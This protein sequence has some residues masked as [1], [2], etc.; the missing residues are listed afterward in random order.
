MK[1]PSLSHQTIVVV[2]TMLLLSTGA[3]SQQPIAVP[4]DS[5]I[6]VVG[7][8]KVSIDYGRPSIHGRKIMGDYVQYNRVWRTGSGK[9][10]TLITEA[11][12]ELGGVEIPM[13]SYSLWT[14][15]S[16]NQWKL[17]IN[18]EVGQWGT[19]YNSEQDLARISLHMK[20]LSKSVDK[21]TFYLDRGSNSSGALRIEWEYTSLSVPF[22]VSSVPIIATRAP[23]E[24]GGAAPGDKNI[25]GNYI[26]VSPRDSTEI[27]LGGKKIAVSYSRPS[28]R[29][30]KIVGSLVPYDKVWRTGANEAT[31]L[32]TQTDLEV[33][34]MVVPKGTYTLYTLPSRAQWKLIINKQTGQWGTEYNASRDLARIKLEKKRLAQLVEKFTIALEHGPG[35]TGILK[36]E[37]EKTSLSIPLALKS[38]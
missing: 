36:I 31:K 6:V 22:K 23:F 27:M 24:S 7:G 1:I 38:K 26:D 30:R 9:S 21:L 20:K 25:A 10:T 37:W 35:G 13:G 5:T 4:R 17:I 14:L 15:P 11:G 16:Q 29:G 32:V 18:K 34:G 28:A 19:V 33:G 2:L 3:R 12:L 8:K